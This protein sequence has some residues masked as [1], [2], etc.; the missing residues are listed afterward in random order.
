MLRDKIGLGLAN[1]L[2]QDKVNMCKA[3]IPVAAKIRKISRD[4]AVLDHI[5][6]PLP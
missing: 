3:R 5:T 2:N 6:Y 1:T 4:I